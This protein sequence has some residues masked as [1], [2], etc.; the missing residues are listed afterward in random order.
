MSLAGLRAGARSA[1]FRQSLIGLRGY[2]S[3]GSSAASPL[4]GV[5]LSRRSRAPTSFGLGTITTTQV[6]QLSQ[7]SGPR[8]VKSKYSVSI[9]PRQQLGLATCVPAPLKTRAITTCA[10]IASRRH[11]TPVQD[12]RS[13]SSDT[14]TMSGQDSA[15]LSVPGLDPVDRRESTTALSNRRSSEVLRQDLIDDTRGY[16]TGV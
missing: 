4:W 13:F 10:P 6:R 7:L 15:R 8:L 9:E 1:C 12:R 11:Q 2:H 5:Q 16:M 14:S 3:T